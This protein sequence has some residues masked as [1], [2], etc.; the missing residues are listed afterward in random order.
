[1]EVSGRF[2][3]LATLS[4]AKGLFKSEKVKVKINFT[5]V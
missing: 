4:M 2:H 3:A 5:I 1:M